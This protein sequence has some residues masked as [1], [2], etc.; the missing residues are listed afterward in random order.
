MDDNF[1][2]L[3]DSAEL[4]F[5]SIEDQEQDQQQQQHQQPQ[6]Q[7]QQTQQQKHQQQQQDQ[8]NQQK[9]QQKQQKQQH[10]L[11]PEPSAP[12]N[13]SPSSSLFE[14]MGME[15]LV[16]AVSKCVRDEID[17][18]HQSIKEDHD[19]ILTKLSYI[20][21][22]VNKPRSPRRR[23]RNSATSE[24]ALTDERIPSSCMMQG[25]NSKRSDSDDIGPPSSM[26]PGRSNHDE[27]SLHDVDT[28]LSTSA[29]AGSQ[30]GSM[31][32]VPELA[33]PY[34]D[35]PISLPSGIPPTLDE[36][37]VFTS[38][39]DQSQCSTNNHNSNTSSN[40]NSRSNFLS[41]NDNK[42]ME[43][44]ARFIAGERLRSAWPLA[45]HRE[46]VLEKV[47][48]SVPGA[49][50]T[51]V[52]CSLPSSCILGGFCVWSEQDSETVNLSFVTV[53]I[54]FK[55]IQTQSSRRAS[56]GGLCG[57]SVWG[58]A[59]VSRWFLCAAARRSTGPTA[60]A[61]AD[62]AAGSASQGA[63]AAKSGSGGTQ[64]G[65]TS[66]TTF[67]PGIASLKPV[68]FATHAITAND[69]QSLITE[70]NRQILQHRPFLPV[71]D[72]H[73]DPQ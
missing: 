26:G 34:Q 30:A 44:T 66:G 15:M 55:V 11:P 36:A 61:D 2:D 63:A 59:F 41:P 23:Q 67:A 37:F 57:G 18:L 58:G 71:W 24:E 31:F 20:F 69:G 33:S 50:G 60:D 42:I 35:I 22:V 46:A 5:V 4:R 27:Q 25:L 43:S 65:T 1:G 14:E 40:N 70:K 29:A 62:A 52:F 7:N 21:E 13:A 64:R 72:S 12:P 9:L 49:V 47:H 53:S 28:E 32:H 8:Q 73:L 16:V 68:A 3:V 39:R 45:S 19:A 56:P 6:Q 54:E 17:F 38:C 10:L 48:E 51:G